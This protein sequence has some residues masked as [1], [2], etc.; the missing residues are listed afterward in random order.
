[1]HEREGVN[2]NM[3]FQTNRVAQS[4]NISALQIKILHIVEKLISFGEFKSSQ[5]M[6]C[7]TSS[8]LSLSIFQRMLFC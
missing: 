5:K 3:L 6:C 7:Q 2:E 8:T 4:G 1:M